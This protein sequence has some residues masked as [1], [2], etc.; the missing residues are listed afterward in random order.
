MDSFYRFLRSLPIRRGPNR[1]IGGVCGG[2]AA[3]FGWDPT[4]VRI[5]TLLLFLV[6][7]IGV[8]GYLVAWLLLPYYDGTI[9]LERLLANRSLGR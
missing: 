5:V 3:K 9:A 8:A 6:P 1:W 4:L 7:G 2:I